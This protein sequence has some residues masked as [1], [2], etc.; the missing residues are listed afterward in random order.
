MFGMFAC[1]LPR[2]CSSRAH[3]STSGLKSSQYGDHKMEDRAI[4]L[5]SASARRASSP[6]E[7]STTNCSLFEEHNVVSIG[8]PLAIYYRVCAD[9]Y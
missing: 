1:S 2:S 8:E 7:H 5:S 3:F 6:D 9:S 4:T